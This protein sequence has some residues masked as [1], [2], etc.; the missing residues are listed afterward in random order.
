MS[1][2][3]GTIMAVGTIT[4]S[5]IDPHGVS[6]AA[7]VGDLKMTVTT[8]VGPS[9]Y[10]TSGGDSVTAKQLGLS[11]VMHAIAQITATSGSNCSAVA[12][13]YSTSTN[14]LQFFSAADSSG[15]PLSESGAI[16]VS[17]L[18]VTITAFGY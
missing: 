3:K 8:V 16:N 2:W 17:G 5:K 4:R 7:S 13:A 15:C 6:A 1:L 18:T 12:A 9:T 14:K 10:T 11:R